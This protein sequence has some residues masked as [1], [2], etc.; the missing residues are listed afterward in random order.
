MNGGWSGYGDWGVCSQTCGGGT[1]SRT[2]TCSNPNPQHGGADCGND[3]TETREC[4]TQDCPS[5]V[6]DLIW[7]L[8]NFTNEKE[9]S[10]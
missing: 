3:H 5:K 8:G 4:N 9:G 2:R 10:Y 1:Q 6:I 7:V